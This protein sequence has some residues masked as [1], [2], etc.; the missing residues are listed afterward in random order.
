MKRIINFTLLTLLFTSLL[1][2]QAT[3]ITLQ[4]PSF[5]DTPKIS[6]VPSGWLDCGFPG[7]TSPD[8]LPAP[9]FSVSRPALDGATYLGLVLRDNDTW[10][11]V[12]QQLSS[13][14][15]VGQCYQFSIFLCRSANYISRSQ[16]TKQ[17]ANY[18]SPA[19]L[20]IWG[21]NTACSK[22]ER[23]AETEV[24]SNYEWKQFD[25]TFKPKQS[26]TYLLLEAFY[27]IPILFP[28]NGNLLLDAASPIIPLVN[29]DSLLSTNSLYKKTFP[30]QKMVAKE[31]GRFQIFSFRGKE[32]LDEVIIEIHEYLLTNPVKAAE[33]YI[34][35]DYLGRLTKTKRLLNKRLNKLGWS[36]K[37]YK[38]QIGNL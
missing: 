29:C 21:G 16:L 32:E 15:V 8:I 27:K 13:P 35:N 20:I 12:G 1:F 25:L 36:K 33:I 30:D 34:S 23:L 4:N 5:E 2:S 26:H 10:E 24:I 17:V 38:F 11:R 14:L 9:I 7:E 31:E 28:Y 18:V 6:T 19:K 37:D 3:E 22:L